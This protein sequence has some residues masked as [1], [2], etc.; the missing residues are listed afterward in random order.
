MNDADSGGSGG[1]DGVWMRAHRAARS[2]GASEEEA[3]AAADDAWREFCVR[4]GLSPDSPPLARA[5][6]GDGPVA[7]ADV[8]GDALREEV[9][10]VWLRAHARARAE[11]LDDAEAR[12]AADERRRQ[13]LEKWNL[14]PDLQGPP[15][16]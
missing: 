6:E 5:G 8:P 16:E 4:W 7:A 2:R 14:P 10:R 1:G 11:G 15:S 9:E 3:R 13:F 12:A